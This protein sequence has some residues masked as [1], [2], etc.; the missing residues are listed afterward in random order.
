[1]NVPILLYHSIAERVAPGFQRWAVSP[2]RFG[3]QLS[4]LRERRYTPL[5]VSQLTRSLGE[6]LPLPEKP[7]VITFDDGFEDFYTAALPLLRAHKSVATLYVTTGYMEGTS[8]WLAAEGE[9]E[10][11]MM[12]WAQL[13]E[14]SR[15]GVECGAHTCTHPQLDTLSLKEAQREIMGSKRA[16]EERLGRA[17]L[18]FA[19]PH[20]YHSPA[21]Q[22]LVQ[23]AGFRSACAVKHAMSSAQDDLFALSRIIIAGDTDI[24]TFGSL[25]EGR[26]LRLAPFQET[27]KTKGWR[28]ARRSAKVLGGAARRAGLK[29]AAHG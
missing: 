28:L 19:Y 8:R 23:Q 9:G 27:W 11:P 16:L 12:S 6:R 26:E 1:M 2:E 3:E 25:L 20:G 29:G 10:R 13:Q 24:Q 5:T 17:V 18:S 4:Y 21:V 14:V 15:S 22:K 7:V